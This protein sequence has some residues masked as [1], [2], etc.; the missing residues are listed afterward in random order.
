MYLKKCQIKDVG[1]FKQFLQ[2]AGDTK[3]SFDNA[4]QALPEKMR[5]TLNWVQT[6]FNTSSLDLKMK[7]L[8]NWLQ[9][10]NSL[11]MKQ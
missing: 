10:Y 11:I 6:T 1:T 8:K 4:K 7:Y 5:H 3:T 2:T 9:N